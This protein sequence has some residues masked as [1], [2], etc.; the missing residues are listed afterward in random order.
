MNIREVR[1][2][3][4]E[5]VFLSLPR[6]LYREDK[7]FI[8]HLDKDIKD[9][10]D[11]DKNSA[12]Q[13]GRA[14]RWVLYNEQKQAIGR[15]AAF[16][17]EGDPKAGISFF[18]CINDVEAAAAL[19]KTAETW[20]KQTNKIEEVEA[21][22][23]FGERDKYWG[24]LV[25][26][27]IGPAYQEPYNFPYYQQLFETNGY[28]KSFEQTTSEL[29]IQEFDPG[30]LGALERR[31][32]S[33]P[34]LEVRHFKYS[35]LNEYVRDF[36]SIYNAAWGEKEFFIPL[37]EERVRDLFKSMKAIVREDLLLFTYYDKRPVAFYISIP[38]IN[39]LFKYVNGRLDV[40]GKLKFLYYRWRKPVTRSRGLV[41]GVIPEFQGRGV[42]TGMMLE[43]YR[44]M[45]EDPHLKCTELSWIGDFNPSMHALFEKIGAKVIKTH[46][47]FSK[48]LK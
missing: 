15:I 5:K 23:N 35:R 42:S 7:H 44:I 38:E 12:F 25:D 31:W 41:F 19:F 14:K 2:R 37:T 43:K 8:S 1:D 3:R 10:F 9:V 48:T 21:P 34:R 30:V 24:L 36:V 13:N 4:D 32:H 20:L 11:P 47:T 26:G 45:K 16:L 17:R 29:C 39:Q 6:D 27:F 28:V 46:Y 18:E 40:L 33:N 22:V